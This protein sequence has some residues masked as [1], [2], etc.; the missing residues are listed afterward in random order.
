MWSRPHLRTDALADIQQISTEYG[1]DLLNL[2]PP[3]DW[4]DKV[5][6]QL[7]LVSLGIALDCVPLFLLEVFAGCAHLTLV[8]KSLGLAVGPPVDIEPA[9]SGIMSFNLLFPEFRK[10]VWA[11][12]VVGIPHWVHV[13]FPCTF[14]S[15]MAHFTRRHD[16]DL[17]ENTR[18]QEL[19]FIIF[20]RQI[21]KWQ[22][23]HGKHFS[24]ENPP[25]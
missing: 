23:S 22:H 24:F 17:D 8:A 13:G 3:P 15:Q 14:W 10:I 2:D 25:R 5:Q 6:C 20:A 21:G 16:P 11:L 12:I 18:L 9:I 7:L 4:C 1:A 19:V